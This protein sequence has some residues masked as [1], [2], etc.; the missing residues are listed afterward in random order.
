[1]FH[2]TRSRLLELGKHYTTKPRSVTACELTRIIR[3]Q[4]PAADFSFKTHRDYAVDPDMIVVAGFYD[5]YDDAQGLPHTVITLCYHPEQDLYFLN[6]LDW[7]RISFDIAECIGHE[8]VHREQYRTKQ[9]TKLYKSNNPN[10][11]YLGDEAEIDAYGFSIAIECVTYNRPIGECA[12]YQAYID[13]FD[14]DHSVIVKLQKAISKYLK[15]L[16]Q[17][18]E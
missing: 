15:Q 9:K 5:C 7:D 4:F 16:E 12:M 14:K 8:L 18:N 1:M 13:T 10:E 6:L 3:R 11:A 2:E 17:N